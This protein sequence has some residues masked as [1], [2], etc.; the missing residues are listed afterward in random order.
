MRLLIH[1]NGH[2]TSLYD[3]AIDLASLGSLSINRA[4]H[5]EPDETGR[6]HADLSPVGGPLLGPF[7]LRSQ[8]LDAERT[9]LEDNWLTA[10]RSI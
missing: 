3:E 1:P 9:W 5:V 6:W 7:E 8:A 10:P 4:S 2:V